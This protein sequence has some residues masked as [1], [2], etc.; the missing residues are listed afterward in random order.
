MMTLKSI[1]LVLVLGLLSACAPAA[2]PVSFDAVE[3]APAPRLPGL[4]HSAY[5]TLQ[6]ERVYYEWGG[7]QGSPV[8]MVHGIG[9]GNSSHL[10]R[11]NTESLAASHR[12]YA[13]DWPGFARSGAR[14]RQY[15]NDLYVAVLEDFIREVV[16]EPV[17][18]V[19]GSLGS[20]YSIRVAAENPE[21]VTQML[22]SNPTGYDLVN[23]ENKEGR[24]FITTTSA[25]N[26]G[27]YEQLSGS[28]LGP[29]IWSIIDSEGGIDFFLLNFVYL[30]RSRVT[31]ELTQ[32]YLDNLEGANK[33]YAPYSFFAGFLEQPVVDYWPRLS[34]PTLLVWS[35]DDI[36]TPIRYAEPMLEDRPDVRL[37]LLTGRA[38]PYDED[39]E[40]FN[41]LA[42]DFL[43]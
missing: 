30:D 12:V 41:A 11:E 14:A 26:E 31:P 28:F 3:T 39:A 33:Q 43:H 8:V 10:W 29:L 13:F 2:V 38:I 17:A 1:L 22:L 5:A 23:P 4:T 24:A 42:K 20:D 36:F 18:I 27:F 34:Q 9:A 15:T 37:E 35:K 6:G 32:I 19:A 21:L 16:G 7:F 25:R 40:H